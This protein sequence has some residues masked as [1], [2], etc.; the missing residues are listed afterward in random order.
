LDSGVTF[1]VKDYG[2]LGDGV[3]DDTVK[4]QY[5]INAA[6]SDGGVVYFPEGV[7]L[8]SSSLSITSHVFLK[9]TGPDVTFLLN[10]GTTT[11]AVT[12]NLASLNGTLTR[13]AGISDM[14]IGAGSLTSTAGNASTG[15]GL[16]VIGANSQ[17]SA[18]N[19]VIRN[20]SAGVDVKNS[21]NA[22]FRALNVWYSQRIGFRVWQS[23]GTTGG[24]GLYD[25]VVSNNGISPAQ[26]AD[27]IAYLYQNG[28]GAVVNNTEL[29][30][31]NNGLV[32]GPQAAESAL[33]G[34]FTNVL[35][36]TNTL[37]GVY[38]NAD[39]AGSKIWS[40]QCAQC[41]S[42]YNGSTNGVTFSGNGVGFKTSGTDIK[43]I[44]LIAPRARENGGYGM[45]LG[46]SVNGVMVAN[47]EVDGN[48]QFNSSSGGIYVG[49]SASNV[50][51]HGGYVGKLAASGAFPSVSG[52][53]PDTGTTN[54]IVTGVN[55]T[56]NTTP[57]AN[58]ANA[59]A[60][61]TF[62][63][64]LPVTVG[65]RM[66]ATLN[67]SGVAFADLGAVIPGTMQWCTNCA[68]ATPCTGAGAGAWAFGNASQ[69][70]CPF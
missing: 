9:G 63:N 28:G 19:L 37:N 13:S 61:W 15:I 4:I 10:T 11:N 34:F 25:S 53:Y 40:M 27:S 70:K 5:A 50:S 12:F 55:L 29:A 52:I 36:D 8:I 46:G 14:T 24:V 22:S 21:F 17:Y 39:A 65:A 38:F 68:V 62:A 2:A 7:Y 41:W 26:D 42:S 18:K 54:L 20:H 45:I 66:G 57:I 69:W 58:L 59:V 35:T 3:T 67:Q 30:L 43:G 64:N 56:T 60:S 16:A 6:T 33:Y 48:N 44:Y 31:F 32:V 47:A 51:I 49:P 23:G 1:N